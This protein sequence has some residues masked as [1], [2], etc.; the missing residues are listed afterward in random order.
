MGSRS[1]D[2]VGGVFAL[3]VRAARFVTRASPRMLA[4]GHHLASPVY[5]ICLHLPGAGV[6][7][8][9]TSYWGHP[10]GESNAPPAPMQL[11]TSRSFEKPFFALAALMPS[12]AG[13][14]INLVQ[15]FRTSMYVCVVQS[16]CGWTGQESGSGFCDLAP[17]ILH[18]NWF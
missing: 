13:L 7:T 17:S 3:P 16:V 5:P 9:G 8:W 6:P 14:A 1:A 10:L 18:C 15:G 4:S 2:L 12:I 11:L